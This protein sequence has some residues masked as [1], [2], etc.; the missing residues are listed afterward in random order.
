MKKIKDERVIALNN[1]IQ[2]EAYILTLFL[3][4][5]S[6]FVK[7]YVMGMSFLEYRFELGIVIISIAYITIRS[8]I[9]GHDSMATFKNRKISTIYIILG[10]SLIVSIINGV[11]NYELYADKYSGIFDGLFISVLVVTFISSTIFLSVI[12]VILY[13]FNRIGQQRIE[14]KINDEEDK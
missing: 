10:S 14:K 13:F 9:M 2:S 7:S 8:M 3:I 5:A 6:M 1:K 12:S 11:K 4:M